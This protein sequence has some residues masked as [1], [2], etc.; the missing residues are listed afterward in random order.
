MVQLQIDFTAPARALRRDAV[1]AAA[2]PVTLDGVTKPAAV[3]AK[4]RG[5]KWQTVKM[6]RM[7]GA[8]WREAL[9][10]GLRVSAWRLRR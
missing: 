6:R 10:P 1:A 9:S 4:E 5:L 8:G 7:R 3:W 2:Q